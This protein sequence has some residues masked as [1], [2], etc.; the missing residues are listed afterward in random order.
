[1][2]FRDAAI[3]FFTRYIPI[4]LFSENAVCYIVPLLPSINTYLFL[5][6]L[7]TGYL[8]FVVYQKVFL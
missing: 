8:V 2:F 3:F 1:M 5:P 4:A 7:L 6:P